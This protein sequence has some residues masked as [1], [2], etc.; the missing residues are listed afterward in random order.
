MNGTYTTPR[1]Q[2]SVSFIITCLSEGGNGTSAVRVEW[3]LCGR[4][5]IRLSEGRIEVNGV[6]ERGSEKKREELRG[7]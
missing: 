6:G 1:I 2:C 7:R 3:I 5:E 4:Q